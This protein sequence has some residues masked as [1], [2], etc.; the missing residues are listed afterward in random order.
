MAEALVRETPFVP[1]TDKQVRELLGDSKAPD[2]VGGSPYLIR[3]VG[4]ARRLSPL[5]A[6]IR[7]NGDVWVGGG[8]ISRCPVAKEHRAVIVWLQEPPKEVFVTFSV[9]E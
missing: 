9:A 4:D 3:A 7:Q 2:R 1:L 6:Y 5:E 8:A